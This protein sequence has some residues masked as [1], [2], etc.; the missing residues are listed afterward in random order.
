MTMNCKYAALVTNGSDALTISLKVLGILPGDEVITTGYTWV[1]TAGAIVQCN[2]VPVF[3]DIDEFS[4]CISPSEIEKNITGKTKAII[5]VHLANQVCNMDE[6][7]SISNRYCIPV[8][9]DCA[10]APYAEWRGKKVGTIGTIGTFS[11]EQSKIMTSGEGGMII[12]NSQHYFELICAF[13]NCGR[14]LGTEETYFGMAMGWNHRMTEFQA[15]VLYGQLL[16]IYSKMQKLEDNVEYLYYLLKKKSHYLTPFYNHD[17]RITRRQYYCII[18]KYEGKIP[19]SKYCKAI[20]LEGAELEDKWY[21]SLNDNPLFHVTAREWPFIRARYGE[22]IDSSSVDLKICRKLVR[23][24]LVWI[25]YPSYNISFNQVE[26]L[27]A[28]IEK[29]EKNINELIDK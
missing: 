22:Q 10:H 27:V 20:R 3:C 11:F 8:I 18:L 2:A 13:L 23:E 14:R 7:M 21:L 12:T 4:G 6:I 25:H 9:E 29:V 16:N 19:L 28:C 26:Q 15:A 1:A 24:N 17:S 5:V